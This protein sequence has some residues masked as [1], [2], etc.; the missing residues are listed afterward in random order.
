MIDEGED[1][2]AEDLIMWYCE[3]REENMETFEQAR[4]LQKKVESLLKTWLKT[5]Y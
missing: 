3:L 4:A 5:V 1:P 2:I